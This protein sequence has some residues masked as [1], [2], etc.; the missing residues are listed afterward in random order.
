MGEVAVR[1]VNGTGPKEWHFQAYHCYPEVGEELKSIEI[2]KIRRRY[3]REVMTSFNING[4]GHR[5]NKI[6]RTI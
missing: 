4:G 3:G 1:D 6:L 2:E 5:S